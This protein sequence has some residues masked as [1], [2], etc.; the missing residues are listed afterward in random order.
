VFDEVVYLHISQKNT[1]NRWF[2][3]LF[4]FSLY[5]N[6]FYCNI[7]VLTLYRKKDNK[8]V[9]TKM[10]MELHIVCIK[11]LLLDHHPYCLNKSRG[12]IFKSLY[13]QCKDSRA[14]GNVQKNYKS[15]IQ[16]QHTGNWKHGKVYII[17]HR[18]NVSSLLNLWQQR[19]NLVW[20][21]NCCIWII[22]HD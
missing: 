7:A 19:E 22:Q 14:Y 11:N 6:P 18:A 15:W 16:R 9:Y 17:I 13:P 4:N 21:N 20:S 12:T 8:H 5:S 3:H 2:I 10:Q 1:N